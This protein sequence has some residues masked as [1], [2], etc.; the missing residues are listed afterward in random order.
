MD[1]PEPTPMGFKKM[2]RLS[3]KAWPFIQP[4]LVHLVI[5][6][7]LS[8]IALGGGFLAG[9]AGL[10]LITNKILIGEKLQ[11]LQAKILLLG[12]EY[13]TTDPVQLGQGQTN[14]EKELSEQTSELDPEHQLTKDQRRTVRNRVII[15]TII[16]ACLAALLGYG[17]YYYT[18]WIWQS[19]NQNL[20]VE[21]VSRVETLSLK[22]HEDSRVGDGVFRVYQDSAM[23]V[24]L[25][26]S[27][28]LEPLFSAG[29]L[30]LSLLV[31]GIF[32][33]WL[34]VIALVTM[35]FMVLI[36][37]LS[38][39]RIRARALANRLANSDL[40]ARTQ[41]SFTFAK[42]VKANNAEG[43]I[44]NRFR[45]DSRHALNA[46]YFLRTDMV[47]VGWLV[48]VVVC[49]GALLS[50]Y[51]I[52]IWV[53]AE[54]ETFK[55]A[56][57]VTLVGF[58]IFNAAAYQ[59]ATLQADG[60]AG[61]SRGLLGT[62]MRI[63]DLFVALERAYFF[64]DVENEV[65]ESE[66]PKQMPESIQTI[67]WNNVSFAYQPNRPVFS[68]LNLQADQG[69]LTAIVGSTGVGKS[70]LM[71]L[72][73]RL[74]DVDQGSVEINGINVREFAISDL[75]QQIAI[76]LQKNV[77][78]AETIANNIAFG[79]RDLSR[80][81]IVNAAKIATADEFIDLLPKGY[82]TELGERGGKLS[83]GQRQRLSIARAVVRNTPVLILDEPT[84]S[85]DAKTEERVL[86]NISDW[87]T[88][89]L[90]FLITH[91]IATIRKADQIAFLEN[92][93]VV[94]VGTHEELIAIPNGSYRT[95]IDTELSSIESAIV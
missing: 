19:V 21:M 73:L 29:S 39:H 88:N 36:A 26:Q 64:L 83:S 11:P 42:L 17:A 13:V 52:V 95:M 84:A 76:A 87:G 14:E 62:W 33:P 32:H 45:S 7:L 23:I 58:A 28:L 93:K 77:L 6:V 38:T 53:I 3:I 60:T 20:R 27:G 41:E 94:E 55:G 51:L 24:N 69:S 80:E 65:K 85:L 90:I 1:S 67:R 81:E 48:S 4:Q 46:A 34:S 16:G 54:Q 9:Y 5:L 25:I 49:I 59:V 78:F 74:M 37:A 30:F 35:A 66:H 31:L 50:E 70:T 2:L 44:L 89:R 91:R 68:E 86:Q 18:M 79:S 75:R 47:G 12:D 43:R 72:L 10:D 61:G 82:D 71:S 56:Y 57:F 92:G 8:G 40:L 15:W 22:F 63:Q